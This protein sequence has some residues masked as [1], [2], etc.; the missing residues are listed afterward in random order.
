ME[1]RCISKEDGTYYYYGYYLRRVKR[2]VMRTF[3][4]GKQ[5]RTNMVFWKIDEFDEEFS[6][7]K[8]AC[9]WIDRHNERLVR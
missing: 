7:K 3:R 2:V 6:N 9:M 8:T 1:L 4:S 5:R